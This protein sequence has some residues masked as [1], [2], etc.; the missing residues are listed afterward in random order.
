ME[1]NTNNTKEYDQYEKFC[2]ECYKDRVKI[3]KIGS[4]VFFAIA[5][6]ALGFSLGGGLDKYGIS[7]SDN[8]G[9]AMFATGLFGLAGLIYAHDAR[10]A[11]KMAEQWQAEFDQEYG[12]TDIKRTR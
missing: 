3:T 6:A 9:P 4:N 12:E 8:L 2:L 5:S 1:N 11:G 7:P 10:K